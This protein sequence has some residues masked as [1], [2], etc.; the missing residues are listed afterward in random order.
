MAGKR[1]SVRCQWCDSPLPYR[2]ADTMSML[3]DGSTFTCGAC[4]PVVK[5]PRV[6]LFGAPEGQELARWSEMEGSDNGR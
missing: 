3:I 1:W 6:A 4:S 5:R 2:Y